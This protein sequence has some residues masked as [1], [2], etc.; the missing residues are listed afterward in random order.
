MTHQTQSFGISLLIHLFL[1]SG[2]LAAGM[3]IPQTR[4][5]VLDLSLGQFSTMSPNLGSVRVT[6]PTAPVKR[7]ERMVTPMEKN[8][9]AVPIKK[10]VEQEMPPAMPAV[11]AS[12]QEGAMSGAADIAGNQE[13]ARAGYISAHFTRIRDKILK[14]ISYPTVARRMGWSGRVVVSFI[15]R[16]D[17]DVEDISIKESSGFPLL[18]RNAVD[19]VR[20]SCP[21]PKP[22]V[23]TA[24]IMPVLYL[25]K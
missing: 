22:P 17:G 14:K 25:L 16:E 20:E 1:V 15:I 21:L 10:N 8:E 7:E 19:A 2:V 23:R 18:D 6:R 5:V 4:T 13:M 24:L 3:Y 9:E 12:M 11:V